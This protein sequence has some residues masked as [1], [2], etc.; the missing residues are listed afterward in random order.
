[1]VSVAAAAILV[2]CG[3]QIGCNWDNGAQILYWFLCA[4]LW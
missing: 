3:T 4:A 2:L 1:M